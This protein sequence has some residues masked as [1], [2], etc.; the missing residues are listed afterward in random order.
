MMVV[1]SAGT[2]SLMLSQNDDYPDLKQA[3]DYHDMQFLITTGP[4]GSRCQRAHTDKLPN[5]CCSSHLNMRA[6]AALAL[7]YSNCQRTS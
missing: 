2:V 7:G 1:M 4:G 5:C 6:E 3:R